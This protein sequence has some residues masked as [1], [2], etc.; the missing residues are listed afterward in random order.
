V[1]KSVAGLFHSSQPKS[2]IPVVGV[3]PNVQ[4]PAAEVA[5]IVGFF[6]RMNA[7]PRHIA[8]IMDGNG[9][10]AATRGLPRVAGHRAGAKSV[11]MMVEE[12]RKAGV[13]YLTLFSFS[14]ENWKR[15]KDE[16]G[17]LMGLFREHLEAELR[18]PELLR[19]GV[20]LRVA[21]D[22]SRLPL[23]VR[24]VL[25]QVLER[26]KKNAELDLILAVSY[27]GREDIVHAAQRLAQQ[28]AKGKLRPADIN[29]EM[30]SANLWT[31]G[32]PDP[33][34]LIRSSG[35]MRISNFLL[36]QLAY[37]EIIVCDELWPDFDA[38]VFHRCLDEFQKRERRFGLTSEQIA[39]LKLHG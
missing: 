14:T 34:L 10:W 5:L 24:T 37:A 20:R 33:D 23:A 9:R 1:E 26:T 3:F 25:N 22:I 18:D 19:N 13:R 39:D 29:A 17:S 2:L 38:A 4:N 28:A 16:V 32:I 7:L 8:V 15:T 36:W 12:C 6:D 31:A 30:F 27:G 35:E 21:G 11:R